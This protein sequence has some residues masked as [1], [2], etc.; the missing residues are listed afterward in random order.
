M[1]QDMMSTVG[2]VDDYYYRMKMV[3]PMDSA[4]LDYVHVVDPK[5]L[6]SAA[7]IKKFE[8]KNQN[9]I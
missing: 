6:R 1:N 2:G 9:Y 7:V 4:V 5:I 3:P 8:K